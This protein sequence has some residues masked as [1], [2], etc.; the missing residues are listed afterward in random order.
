MSDPI[1]TTPVETVIAQ[2]LSELWAEPEL[3]VDS[4]TP[5]GDGHSGFTYLI[6]LTSRRHRGRFV[7]RLSPPGARIAGPADIGRQGRIM[8]AL[9]TAGLAVPAI[10]AADS[11]GLAGGRALMV[12]EHVKGVHWSQVAARHGQHVV[13]RAAVDFLHQVRELP[14]A[15]FA[16]TDSPPSTPAADVDRWAALL[17]RCPDWLREPAATLHRELLASAPPMTTMGLVHGDFHYGNMLFCEQD[18]AAVFDW[19]IASIGDPRLDLGSL[20]VASLRA[21]YH[22]EPN[23]TG[24]VEISVDELC[25]LYGIRPADAVWFIAAGC[26]KYAAI[27]GYNLDLHRRRKRLDPVYE[28][29]VGTMAGLADDGR[30]M[31]RRG[32]AAFESDVGSPAAAPSAGYRDGGD[33]PRERTAR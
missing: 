15:T 9:G 28:E 26:L 5:F 10:L 19:E 3:R 8:A 33:D 30:A 32:T 31:L 12:M 13:A 20:A 11:T 22:P 7:A 21:R 29:L 27:L 17:P 23:P 6:E 2:A 16:L 4:A 18:I 1:A 25:D 24:S 14:P